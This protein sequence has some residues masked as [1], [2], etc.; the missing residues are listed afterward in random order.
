MRPQIGKGG[1][2]QVY[3]DDFEGTRS[4][5]DLRF[6]LIS[7]NLASTPK[8]FPESSFSN[9]LAYGYN[10][11]KIAWYNIEPVLQEKN[12]NNNPLRNDPTELSKPETRQVLRR[13]I[14]PQQTNDFG[15]GLLTTFDL[16]FYPKDKGPYNYETRGTRI[17]P[18]GRLLNPTQAWGGIMRNIDQIDFETGNI[19]YIEFWLQ[20]PFIKNTANPSNTGRLYFNLGNISE[21]ILKDGKRGI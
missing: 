1:A 18:N 4:S 2:G 6:P 9:D 5:I 7:W 3:I 21:D 15:Q 11:A 10:R 16:A 8:L 19:E 13:E 20:D 14:F 12:N 17:D